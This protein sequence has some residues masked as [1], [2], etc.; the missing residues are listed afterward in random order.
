MLIWEWPRIVISTRR[1]TAG[2]RVG[3]CP[4]AARRWPSD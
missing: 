3:S 1:S 4:R 2:K